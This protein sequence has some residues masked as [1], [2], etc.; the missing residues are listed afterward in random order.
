MRLTDTERNFIDK[1]F[2]A[3]S[4]FNPYDEELYEIDIHW[5]YLEALP[6]TVHTTGTSVINYNAGITW[7]ISMDV[8]RASVYMIL[9]K[10]YYNISDDSFNDDNGHKWIL[11][12]IFGNKNDLLKTPQ[13][14]TYNN[15]EYILYLYSNNGATDTQTFG[16]I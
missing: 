9:P 1:F 2:T 13:V 3:K 6:Y 12:D 14:F 11:T 7:D 16:Q 4:I 5:D 10:K 8:E 15:I